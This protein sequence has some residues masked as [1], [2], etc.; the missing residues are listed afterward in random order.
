MLDWVGVGPR[1]FGD[2][3]LGT[4]LDN[5]MFVLDLFILYV[6]Q[7]SHDMG[8]RIQC[9]MNVISTYRSEHIRQSII[10]HSVYITDQQKDP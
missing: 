3:G 7:L 10:Y 2:K 6:M 4:G 5:L 8:M 9:S 1:S